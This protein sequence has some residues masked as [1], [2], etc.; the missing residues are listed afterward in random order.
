LWYLLIFKSL[1]V[2]SK[3]FWWNWK[4]R[5]ACLPP[6]MDALHACRDALTV[7]VCVNVWICV[8]DPLTTATAIHQ[9]QTIYTFD[10]SKFVLNI[11]CYLFL[12]VCITK[13]HPWWFRV[14]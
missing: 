1:I 11:V 12:Y 14:G 13:R 2:P 6:C 9:D 10:Y 8:C 7:T 4:P 3:N 5:P